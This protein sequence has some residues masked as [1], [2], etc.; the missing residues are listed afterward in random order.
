MAFTTGR[1]S[2]PRPPAPP[3]SLSIVCN[4]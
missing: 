2:T 4:F 1:I 3:P